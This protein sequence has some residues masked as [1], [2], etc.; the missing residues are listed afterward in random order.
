ML[1]ISDLITLLY[2]M[3][4]PIRLQKGGDPNALQTSQLGPDPS[5]DSLDIEEGALIKGL[6]LRIE[7]I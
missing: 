5:H 7:T 2:P 1:K 3:D 4:A 6:L